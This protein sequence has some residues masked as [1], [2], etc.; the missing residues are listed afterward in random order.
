M[1]GLGVGDSC[2]RE[3]RL[4]LELDQAGRPGFEL[5]QAVAW[6]WLRWGDGV[7]VVVLCSNV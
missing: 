4:G 5:G 3:S 6:F 1:L 7:T 2:G